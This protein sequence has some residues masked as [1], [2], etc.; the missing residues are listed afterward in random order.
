LTGIEGL[1]GHENVLG[2]VFDHPVCCQELQGQ[3]EGVQDE[4]DQEPQHDD[5]EDDAHVQRPDYEAQ[6]DEVKQKHEQQEKL[7]DP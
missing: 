6:I 7:D 1:A 2:V 4:Q 3:E 5:R